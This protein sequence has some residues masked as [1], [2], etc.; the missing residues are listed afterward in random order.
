MTTREAQTR[1]R[2]FAR[3][4]GPWLIIVPGIIELRASAMDALATK[5]FEDE[6]FVWFA[7]ALLLFIGPLII[8]FP[9][10][11]VERGCRNDLV[12]WLDSG[13][14]RYCTHGRSQTV[15][16]RRRI[17]VRYLF[18]GLCSVS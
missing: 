17:W 5:F 18:C 7:G 10:V 4:I 12:V 9:P 2:L 3:V 13:A 16:A 8:A 15:R 14:S 1:T 6:L 11:L